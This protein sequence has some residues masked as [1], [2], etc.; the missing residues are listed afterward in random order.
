MHSQYFDTRSAE[1]VRLPRSRNGK[2]ILIG[3]VIENLRCYD[4]RD[5]RTV[6]GINIQSIV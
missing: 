1:S 4:H 6:K 5:W 3:A 2:F